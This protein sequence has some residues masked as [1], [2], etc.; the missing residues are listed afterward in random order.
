MLKSKFIEQVANNLVELNKT[1]KE[2]FLTGEKNLVLSEPKL[3]DKLLQIENG[4][5]YL[6]VLANEYRILEGQGAIKA[7]IKND[8]AI[9]NI[10]DWDSFISKVNAFHVACGPY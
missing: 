10:P 9:F 4:K 8:K 5:S 1:A 7:E 6:G 2:S 3:V